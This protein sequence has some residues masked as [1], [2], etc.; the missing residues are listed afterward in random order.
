MLRCPPRGRAIKQVSSN[1]S[2]SYLALLYT[3]RMEVDRLPANS[4]TTERE[5]YIGRATLLLQQMSGENRIL[6]ENIQNAWNQHL[7]L[8]EI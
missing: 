1:R 7:P 3:A 6:T 8:I 2:C 5:D 4:L